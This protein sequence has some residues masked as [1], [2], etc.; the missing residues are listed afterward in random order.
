MRV[1]GI[2]PGT[3]IL[4]YGVVD[5]EGI[6]MRMVDCGVLRQSIK[7]PLEQRLAYLY[8]GLCQ[9]MGNYSPEEV[10]IEEPFVADNVHSALALGRAQAIAMLVASN[11]QLPV[12]RYAPTLVKQNVTNSGN[13]SKEQ[14]QQMVRIQLGLD[15]SPKPT[16]ASDALAVAICHLQ[17]RKLGNLLAKVK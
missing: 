17:Q 5:E 11:S 6:R 4:G 9:V 15:Q 16:D 14:V 3:L 7:T 2:D 13:S 12:F 8:Q 10:A 1:L